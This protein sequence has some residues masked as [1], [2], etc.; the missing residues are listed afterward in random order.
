MQALD[1]PDAPLG[2]LKIA[3]DCAL[4]KLQP[5]EGINF[6]AVVDRKIFAVHG[7]LS[8]ELQSF[9]QIS[10]IVRPV[11]VSLKAS[12]SLVNPPHDR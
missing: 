12:A 4:A 11:Y 7:G 1:S 2:R 5:R 9:S 3:L 8:P 10:D 6:A